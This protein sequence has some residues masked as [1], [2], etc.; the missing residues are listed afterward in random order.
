MR[1][2]NGVDDREPEAVASAPTA[3]AALEG[4]GQPRDELG[5]DRRAVVADA[6]DGLAAAPRQLDA[7]PPTG[8][9]VAQRVLGEVADQPLQERLV[10]VHAG[11]AEARVEPD[12]AGRRGAGGGDGALRRP[13][14]GR[15]ARRGACLRWRP[16]ARAGRRAAPRCARSCRRSSRP[17][18][19]GR[20]SSLWDRRGRPR[21]PPGSASAACAAHGWRWTRSAAAP[22]R[23]PRGG[24][25]CGLR[26]A[27]RR[28][29]RTRPTAIDG[30]RRTGRRRRSSTGL[31]VDV[32]KRA[33]QVAD[34][35]AASS[36]RAAAPPRRPGA[37]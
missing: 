11:V 20:R 13:A 33:L 34:A 29:A 24:R 2:G 22:R 21:P 7:C 26:P 36:R 14:R 27:T 12:A 18:C 19:A 15:R 1:S 32:G 35:A 17:W 25:A 10:A 23:R 5:R 30:E 16:R 9:A 31:R 37:R 28:R 6:Q 3:P 4:L 8:A